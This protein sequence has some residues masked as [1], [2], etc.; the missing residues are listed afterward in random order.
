M[1]FNPYTSKSSDDTLREL[2]TDKEGL[3][4]SE[5]LERLKKYGPNKVLRSETTWPAVLLRQLKSPFIYLLAGAALLAFLLK[6][7][8]DAAMILAF[9]VIN[10][11]LGF[12]QEF[13]SEQIIKLLT[14]YI[15]A[16]VKVKRDGAEMQVPTEELVPGDILILEPGEILAADARVLSAESLAVDESVL[17]GE[18]VP[19][20]KD[21]KVLLV[22]TK[23]IYKAKNMVFS[24]TSVVSG[25]GWAVITAT[26]INTAI[27]EVTKL[28]TEIVRESTFEKEVLRLSRFIL[29]LVV[30]TLAFIFLANVFIKGSSTNHLEF[31]VFTI[32]LAVSVIPE[33]LPVVTT[34]SFSRGALRLAKHKVVVKRLSAVEGLGAI[35]VLCTDKTGTLTENEMRI[36][37]VFSE[38]EKDTLFHAMLGSSA[39]GKE[40]PPVNPFDLAIWNDL[41]EKEKRIFLGYSKVKEIPFDSTRRR[42]TNLLKLKN[43]YILVSRGAPETIV[44]LC[45]KVP[46]KLKKSISAWAQERGIVGERV[47]AIARKN[48][49]SDSKKLE[50]EEKD[51]EFIG[52]ISFV[53]PIKVTAGDAVIKAKNL[54][55]KIVVLTGD[56][57]EIAGAVS[58]KIGLIEDPKDVITGEE[59]DK[60][61]SAKQRE[62]VEKYSVFARVSPVQKYSI[63][64]LLQE[65]Y[66]VG[67]LGE[68]INDAPALK[69]ANVA[70]A[71]NGASD[72]A[73]EA[74]DIVLLKKDL[75][76]IVN[77]VKEGREIFANTTKYI[78]GTLAANFG[79]FYSVAI[80][81][82]FITFLPML[83]PQILL[84][85]LLS[86]F[87]MIAI[88]TDNVDAQ[89]LEKPKKY[90]MK[91]IAYIA[92]VLGIVSSVFDFIF[93]S[94]F[95]RISAPVLQT[96]WFMESILS[97]LVFIFS[98]RSRKFFLKSKAPSTIL[99]GL[100]V[101]ASLATIVLPFTRL[102]QLLFG[103][104]PLSW[105]RILLIILL[106]VAYFVTTEVVKLYYFKFSNNSDQA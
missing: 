49:S 69:I 67:F 7:R 44:S 95:F 16:K 39:V 81:S 63:T 55:I 53:D 42:D 87:P 34:F 68:G 47:L 90:N 4:D 26:G 62:V 102:G 1:D 3:T 65:K 23:E 29:R 59:F 24:G 52:L 38:S 89:D 2:N 37:A 43:D 75:K 41:S 19:V 40:G 88:A 91:S 20:K 73:R 106:V 105:A 85:N 101:I 6:E 64:Q 45:A 54:G 21:E 94:L 18:S 13:R 57:K 78:T 103:F 77:G 27:G 82:L 22:P 30:I 80:S 10:T 14:K 104:Q 92:T 56:A 76:V 17:T 99:V 36:G 61:P 71:V 96:G 32:A 9:V 33:A 51:L 28:A 74:S 98:V 72:V 48:Y 60:L 86:D 50:D 35:E 25:K 5:V 66:E 79:N 83:P 8:I 11:L 31:L 97:E 58:C 46:T 12:Y 93:F 84:V 15:S 100:V 70:I